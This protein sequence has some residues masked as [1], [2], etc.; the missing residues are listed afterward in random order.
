MISTSNY[1]G[2]THVVFGITR[3][4]YGTDVKFAWYLCCKST[5]GTSLDWFVPLFFSLC[6]FAIVIG[7]LFSDL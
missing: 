4:A 6:A 7:E 5:T 1:F 3:A 2:R